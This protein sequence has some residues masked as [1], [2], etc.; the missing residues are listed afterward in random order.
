MTDKEKL[1]VY[2]LLREAHKYVHRVDMDG[3]E[4]DD[5]LVVEAVSYVLYM[6][7]KHFSRMSD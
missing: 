5:S 4:D 7:E 2:D 1:R 3:W 6:A